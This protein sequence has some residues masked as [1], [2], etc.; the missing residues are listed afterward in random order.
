MLVNKNLLGLYNGVSQQ[1]ASI[2]LDSQCAVQENAMSSLVDGLYKRPPSEIIA[3]LSSVAVADAG[4]HTIV[5]DE[6]ERYIVIFTGD[7]TDPIEV[8][9]MNGD[10]KVVLHGNYYDPLGIFVP[11]SDVNDYLICDSPR[12]DIRATTVGDYTII[13][14]KTIEGA[15]LT[16][17]EGVDQIEYPVTYEAMVYVRNMIQSID[18][19]VTVGSTTVTKAS[20]AHAKTDWMAKELYDLLVAAL[21][22]TYDFTLKGSCIHIEKKDGTD[23]KFSVADGWGNMAMY[24]F[25]GTAQ[26]LQ[27]LP[28]VAY[29]DFTCEI[30]GESVNV[31]DNYYVKYTTDT[32][33][34]TGVWKECAKQGLYNEMDWDTLP[35][36]LIRIS[37]GDFIFCPIRY[38]KRTV[39]D[40]VSASEPSFIGNTINDVFFHKNRL[41]FL[42]GEN[43]I[44]SKSGE[45]WQFFPSTVMDVLDD[46]PI[47]VAASSNQVTILQHGIPFDKDVV[48]MSELQ[49]FILHAGTSGGITP[50]N[51]ACDMTTAFNT[52]KDCRPVSAGSNLYFTTPQGIHSAIREYYVNSESLTNDAADVTAHAPNYLPANIFKLAACPTLDIIFALS[53]DEPRNVYVYKFYWNGNEKAQSSWS[54]WIFPVDIIDI[55]CVE[56][57]LYIM[58]A[59]VNGTHIERLNIKKTSTGACAFTIHLDRQQLVDGTYDVG[60]DLTSFTVG[61]YYD[62]DTFHVIDVDSGARILE[63][64]IIGVLPVITGGVLQVGGDYSD[65]TLCIGIPY[66]MKYQFSEWFIKANENLANLAGVLKMRKVDIGFVDTGYMKVTVT[67][68]NRDP[69]VHEYTAH[70]VGVSEIGVA[71]ILTGTEGFLLMCNAKGSTVEISND[72]Y[73]PTEIHAACFEGFYSTRSKLV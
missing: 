48:L 41:C 29:D 17:V 72:T 54:K 40:D 7:A 56:N 19:K 66:T 57:Y 26:A 34:Q 51:A 8:F 49:Q 13:T 3:S 32:D 6:T 70:V 27:D 68:L 37:S 30:R 22:G 18:Y 58:T 28:S 5:R 69:L 59:D 11:N 46:D 53:S 63:Q 10:K 2:R 73:L 52:S 12:N 23:F 35:H 67:P 4:F 9:D 14:N 43:V 47:D 15:M 33:Y 45:F 16:T 21:S 64:P 36:R 1:P 42:S 55:S 50:S 20:G 61:T 31:F 39:G 25:K 60:T 71:D 62:N 38:T 24:G 44:M 65:K